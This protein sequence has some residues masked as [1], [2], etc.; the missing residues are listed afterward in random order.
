MLKLVLRMPE[1]MDA[2]KLMLLAVAWAQFKSNN[3]Y[4][5]GV[6]YHDTVDAK[7]Y[8]DLHLLSL[9]PDRVFQTAI[10]RDKGT[11]ECVVDGYM[12]DI[13][14]TESLAD[15]QKIFP[16]EM[17]FENRGKFDSRGWEDN[18]GEIYDDAIWTLYHTEPKSA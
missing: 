15:L 10:P 18:Y 1:Q 2:E 9:E 6:D 14:I 11:K 4:S 16:F 12:L 13:Y 17:H 5:L 7:H 3:H 8:D